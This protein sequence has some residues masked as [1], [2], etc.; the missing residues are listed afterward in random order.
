MPLLSELV[1]QG[2]SPTAW[3]AQYRF[4]EGTCDLYWVCHEAGEREEGQS[5]ADYQEMNKASL[6]ASFSEW[7]TN[8]SIK[9]EVLDF[10]NVQKYS[11]EQ[12]KHIDDYL[13]FLVYW[14]SENDAEAGHN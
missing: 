3:Q 6:I 11:E 9:E 10:E 13:Y 1:Y 8:K 2:F 14:R 5:W 4:P 7:T 12:R